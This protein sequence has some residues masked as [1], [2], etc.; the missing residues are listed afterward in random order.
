MTRVRGG[1]AAKAGPGRTPR[2]SHQGGSML[3]GAALVLGLLATLGSLLANYAWR[4]AQ[5]EE[6][7]GALRAAVSAA[8]PTLGGAGGAGNAAIEERVG[9]F[10]EGLLPRL[11]L[12][13][14]TVRH[15]TG[16]GV[17]TVSMTGAYTFSRIWR[18]GSESAEQIGESVDV[19]FE[20][21]SH[22][23]AVAIDLSASMAW[24]IAGQEPGTRVVKLDALKAAMQH[25]A[26]A[27]QTATATTPGSM[28]VSLVPFAS[29]VNAADTAGAGTPQQRGR[30]AGKERYLRMLAGAEG[31]RAQVLA[32]ARARGGHWVDTF[33]HYG[34]G[35]NTG[36]LRQQSLPEDL[37]DGRDWNLRRT[38]VSID[39]SQ[40]VPQLG[41]WVV[42]D[43]D[44]WNGCLMARWG[45]YWDP[46]ARPAGWSAAWAAE[47]LPA[48]SW[49]D[50]R[51]TRSWP[52]TMA[53][54]AWSAGAASLPATTPLHLSDAPP[55]ADAPSTLFTAYSWPD[56]RIGGHADHRL[57]TVMAR[58][59]EVDRPGLPIDS[60]DT[61]L[62]DYDLQA[63]NDWSVT[64]SRGGATLCPPVPLTP[65]TD[66]LTR[67]A[68]AINELATVEPFVPCHG[69]M[70]VSATYL[71]LGV[72]WGLR[73]LSPLWREVWG[74][75]DIQEVPRPAVP[76]APGESAGCTQGL[77]KSILLVSD[78]RS[79]VGE[80][81][82]ATIRH[83]AEGT[84]P[85][86]ESGLT[87]DRSNHRF[88]RDY[89]A[90]GAL[91][92]ESAFNARF[93]AYLDGSRFGGAELDAVLDAFHEVGDRFANDT[94]ERRALRA[95]A[96]RG[97]TPWEL[98][99]G[100][101]AGVTDLLMDET[102]GFGF[103][104]RPTQIGPLCRPTGLFGPYGRPNDH[105]YAGNA[106][107][108]TGGPLPPV[109]D[110]APFHFEGLGAG[111]A[112]T[113]LPGS[114]DD[115]WP[116]HTALGRRLDDWFANACI[117][118]GARGVRV[119]AIF[120]G[121]T[122]FNAGPISTLET[123][124]DRAGGTFGHRD[125]FVTPDAQSLADAFGEIFAID[126]S[127]RFL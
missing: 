80:P 48:R 2:R 120:I 23:V 76:C 67:I 8:G 100:R 54:D 61:A 4:E 95:A 105:V 15:D 68:N 41:N 98:F 60:R 122:R 64:G 121:G 118:A 12:G 79:I 112:L 24:E 21:R 110:V 117:D 126:R 32:A 45:A 108:V 71:H 30:T 26:T 127:L 5:W 40:A 63:D 125:V 3:A 92:T 13:E 10:V 69:C 123:C 18:A 72:V 52:A 34:V 84:N 44:F 86:W 107:Q 7:R 19:T 56:A 104:R 115:P 46:D 106:A 11:D 88:L 114:H 90:T 38:N 66:D 111:V 14:V 36:P 103:E 57:Q 16:T 101:S 113:N 37:L 78:G 47:A 102:N 89:H 9:D 97:L 74:V 39:V 29:A 1:R 116:L 51:R 33:H 59:L 6:I 28:M 75:Q 94:P 119:H 42:D 81:L 62:P 85:A 124:V 73:A 55:D 58:L 17:T 35:A 82:K 83:A 77:Q 43:E 65:L 25:I 109:P 20:A 50:P 87:C 53:V 49:G 96:L 27:M 31:T 99:R 91:E 22:E 93:G 70:G